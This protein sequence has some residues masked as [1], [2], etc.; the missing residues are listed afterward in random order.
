ML[1]AQPVVVADSDIVAAQVAVAAVPVDARVLAAPEQGSAV[2]AE[3][4]EAA[5]TAAAAVAV[6]IEP[7]LALVPEQGLELL[8]GHPSLQRHQ[9]VPGWEALSETDAAAAAR[10]LQVLVAAFS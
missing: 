9:P 3:E 10:H 5:A 2:S 1:M 4:A 6:L 7:G 8:A